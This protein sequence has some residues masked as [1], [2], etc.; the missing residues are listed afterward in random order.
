MWQ[1]K[2]IRKSK[3]DEGG[4]FPQYKGLNGY[5]KMAGGGGWCY[6]GVDLTR[7]GWTGS[8]RMM[9]FHLI[10]NIK[11]EFVERL[12]RY[13]SRTSCLSTPPSRSRAFPGHLALSIE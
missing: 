8:G 1:I 3:Y 2:P 9:V 13:H 5:R 6:G 11:R 10:M 4:F 7:G 12:G